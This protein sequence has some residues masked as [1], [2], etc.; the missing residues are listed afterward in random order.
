M[1]ELPDQEIAKKVMQDL[2]NNPRYKDNALT[3][4]GELHLEFLPS[5]GKLEKPLYLW[6]DLYHGECRDAEFVEDSE[7]KPY[8]Y[9]ISANEDTWRDLFHDKIDPSRAM[10]TGKFKIKGNMAKL[11]RY[12]KAAA[13]ILKYL[14]RYL[15]EW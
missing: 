12:P 11:M 2:N 7:S 8:E 10:M 9:V 6:L 15:K 1:V 13:Y 5:N 4:E 3:W 14:K